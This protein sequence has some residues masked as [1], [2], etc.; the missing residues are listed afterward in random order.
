[1]ALVAERLRKML[2][3]MDVPL[4]GGKVLQVT[5]SFGCATLDEKFRPDSAAELLRAADEAVYK[6]K[7]AGRNRT[8]SHE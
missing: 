8:V 7:H 2:E 5:A 6:A 1:V 3:K 4:G